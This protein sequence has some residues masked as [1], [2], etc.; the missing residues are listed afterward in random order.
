MTTATCRVT[1]GSASAESDTYYVI[2]L[3]DTLNLDADGQPKS[4]FAP[5][6]TIWF[7]LH[8]QPGYVPSKSYQT[9]GQVSAAGQVTLE[10]IQEGAV[11]TPEDLSVEL[12]YY[13][14]GDVTYDWQGN[15]IALSPLVGR[16]ST[17]VDDPLNIMARAII[18]YPVMFYR[19]RFDPPSGLDLDEGEDYQIDAMITLESTT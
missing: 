12:T 16:T 5:G 17:A 2:E 10:R 3:D 9:D 4:T 14:A 19:Y 6:E 11:W 8:L 18:T 1:F 13:P 15:Q 7:L